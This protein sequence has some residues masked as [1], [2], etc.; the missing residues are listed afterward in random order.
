MSR[1]IPRFF[2]DQALSENSELQ[3]PARAAEHLS[4][5]LRAKAGDPI[6]LFNGQGGEWPAKLTHVERKSVT[7]KLEAHVEID[8][9]ASRKI[10][11]AQCISRADRM[12]YTVQKATELGV[13]AIQPLWSEGIKRFKSAE[14]NQKKTNHW[15]AVAQS[16]AEQCGRTLLPHIFKPKKLADWQPPTKAHCWIMHPSE[17]IHNA[18]KG[19]LGLSKTTASIPVDASITLLVGPESGFTQ[20]DLA[21]AE[22]LGFQRLSFGPR[23]LR[24]ETAG[25]SLMAALLTLW[26]DWDD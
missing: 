2:V 24:T 20:Q 12:D 10:T 18:P 25:P 1:H 8:R 15:R 4:R 7:A 14:Q 9:E 3:L 17:T 19:K 16:A 23:I 22:T 6:I 21:I 5:V 26:G 11:L 13:T